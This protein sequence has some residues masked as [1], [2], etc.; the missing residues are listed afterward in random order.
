MSSDIIVKDIVAVFDVAEDSDNVGKQKEEAF[1]RSMHYFMPTETITP[2]A[3]FITN[4]SNILKEFV[5]LLMS[6]LSCNSI[7]A[8]IKPSAKMQIHTPEPFRTTNAS[9]FN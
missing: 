5:N 3:E 9:K 8:P 4:V 6:A 2:N 1:N 7:A